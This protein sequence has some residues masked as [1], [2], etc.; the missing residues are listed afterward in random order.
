MLS[1][2]P[3]RSG[4]GP[5]CC[6]TLRFV[7]FRLVTFIAFRPERIESFVGQNGYA[8]LN[9]SVCSLPHPP[10]PS[11]FTSC[12][13]IIIS[14]V[15]IT[16]FTCYPLHSMCVCSVCKPHTVWALPPC[17][18]ECCFSHLKR[19]CVVTFASLPP[20]NQSHGCIC[21]G[22]PDTTKRKCEENGIKVIT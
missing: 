6:T 11:S 5:D 9:L 19:G 14:R 7:P 20:F 2:L 17:P 13:F 10:N 8:L 4:T 12:Q 1:S 21:L 15:Y 16:L 18:I 22:W 3:G